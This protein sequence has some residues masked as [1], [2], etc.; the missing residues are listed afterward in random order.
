MSD[1][2]RRK[3]RSNKKINNLFKKIKGSIK[4]PSLCL[5]GFLSKKGALKIIFVAFLVIF[6]SFYV[7]NNC[8][9][10]NVFSETKEVKKIENH[11]LFIGSLGNNIDIPEV[12]L[13]DNF[14]I[15]ASSP[16]TT[17]SFH[18]LG[19]LAGIY[20]FDEPEIQAQEKRDSII[21]HVLQKGETLSFLALKYNISL[22]TILW[23]ND[24]NKNSTLKEGQ[25]LIIL[26]VSGVVHYVKS[27]DTISKIAEKYR[28]KTS[29][30]VDFNQLS[31]EADIYI[32]DFVIVPNGKM[33]APVVQKRTVVS[34]PAP[35]SSSAVPST[36]LASSYFIIPVSS[37][38]IITQGLHHF[39]AIDFSHQGYACGKPVF[40]AAAGTVQRVTYSRAGYGNYLTILHPNGVVTLYAHLS[41]I[42]VTSGRTVSQGDIIGYIGN[43]GYT[44][45]ATGCH[46][47]FEVRG[48]P[49]PFGR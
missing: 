32:G 7:K 25:K 27:G 33:P 8:F 49:N 38:Y 2:L 24:L 23:A 35:S 17:A 44:I 13:V 6:S 4:G 5:F 39:N 3:L 28:G 36:P 40:A 19:S 26:P 22:E 46:L 12:I 18:S 14:F 29:E 1:Y 43:S 48:A 34:T 20:D 16:P 42:T 41:A 21:E 9:D 47:H 15:K 31:G 30:I 11:D 10:I 37:P 45:G